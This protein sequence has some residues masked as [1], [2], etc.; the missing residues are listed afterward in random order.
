V[1]RLLAILFPPKPMPE[2]DPRCKTYDFGG[3]IRNHD[4]ARRLSLAQR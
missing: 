4:T 3:L 2:P 1:K